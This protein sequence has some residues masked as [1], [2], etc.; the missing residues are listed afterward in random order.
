MRYLA[1]GGVFRN[2]FHEVNLTLTFFPSELDGVLTGQLLLLRLLALDVSV[3]QLF[4]QLAEVPRAALVFVL[5]GV[6]VQR[7]AS[8]CGR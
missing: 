4:G 8:P 7:G 3:S 6:V 5:L 2:T 1:S